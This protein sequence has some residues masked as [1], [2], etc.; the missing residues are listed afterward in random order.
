MNSEITSQVS[1]KLNENEQKKDLITL[2][3]DSIN[4]AIEAKILPRIYNTIG[5]QMTE[6][7]GNADLWSS[8]LNGTAEVR[9]LKKTW[10][11]LRES[12]LIISDQRNLTSEN[13][14][15]SQR[16]ESDCNIASC[17]NS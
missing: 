9:N 1:R 4:S 7:E 13:S 14:L 6:F 12:N 17:R 16:S 2:I 3:L 5:R 10:G 11:N 15:D 8:S